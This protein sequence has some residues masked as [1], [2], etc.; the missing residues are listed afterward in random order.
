MCSSVRELKNRM[1]AKWVSG[2]GSGETSGSRN[3]KKES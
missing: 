3:L 1:V 2:V